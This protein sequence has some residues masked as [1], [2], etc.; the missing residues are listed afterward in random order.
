MQE[1]LFFLP[2][3]SRIYT[4]PVPWL[5]HIPPDHQ[6]TIQLLR[7]VLWHSC[8][9]V[10]PVL[11]TQVIAHSG[12]R[13]GKL[14]GALILNP[15]AE[16]FMLRPSRPGRLRPPGVHCLTLLLQIRPQM[17]PLPLGSREAI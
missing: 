7:A 6:V 4:S 14:L 12:L 1:V 3:S 17:H 16:A 11:S 8:L 5:V 15:H 10:R 2:N 9:C 13:L